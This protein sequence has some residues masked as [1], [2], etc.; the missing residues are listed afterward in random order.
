MEGAI[1]KQQYYE[2]KRRIAQNDEIY[3]KEMQRQDIE[4]YENEAEK[5]ERIEMELL[6]KLQETQKAE[7]D[8]YGK[9]ENAI[10]D[11]SI[12]K[13]QRIHQN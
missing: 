5:L 1:R 13:K 6:A 8:A 3:D 4:N 10:I 9:L 11:T 12:P 7:R 2:Q